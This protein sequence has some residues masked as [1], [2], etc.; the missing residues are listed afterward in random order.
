MPVA[1]CMVVRG[2]GVRSGEV[3]D[4]GCSRPQFVVASLPSGDQPEF[5]R[6][7]FSVRPIFRLL[8]P[9]LTSGSDLFVLYVQISPRG[10]AGAHS[11]AAHVHRAYCHPSG[12]RGRCSELVVGDGAVMSTTAPSETFRFLLAYGHIPGGRVI[13]ASAAKKYRRLPEGGGRVERGPIIR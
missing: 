5:R 3:G 7:L 12:R 9:H 10:A 6:D 2:W 4:G 13:T 11:E 8:F 1:A